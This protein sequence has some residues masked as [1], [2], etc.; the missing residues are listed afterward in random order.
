[1]SECKAV[2]IPVVIGECKNYDIDSE[3]EKYNINK[4]QKLVGELL[5]LVLEPN[6][7]FITVITSYLS[8]FNHNLQ[9]KHYILYKRV[10]RYLSGTK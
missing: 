3:N 10:L 6:P 9:K 2:S 4:Y 5:Y 7:I 1:M 8:Q